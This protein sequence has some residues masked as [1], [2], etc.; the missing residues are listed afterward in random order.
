[1]FYT[2][3]KHGFSTNQSA[4]TFYILNIYEQKQSKTNPPPQKKQQQ[5]AQQQYEHLTFSHKVT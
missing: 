3:I 2:W 5:Q 4:R 1:M